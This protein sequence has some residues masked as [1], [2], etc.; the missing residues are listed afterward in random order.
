MRTCAQ[1]GSICDSACCM[2]GCSQ[3]IAVSRVN[4]SWERQWE[5]ST[6]TMG[7]YDTSLRQGGGG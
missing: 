2:S 5:T 6:L 3:V 1:N 7:A 4:R